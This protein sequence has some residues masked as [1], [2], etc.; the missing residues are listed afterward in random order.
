[1]ARGH[2]LGRSTVLTAASCAMT[3]TICFGIERLAF[4]A[5][6]ASPIEA[7]RD[8]PRLYVL[9]ATHTIGGTLGGALLGAV[10]N[11]RPINGMFALM[12]LMFLIGYGESKFQ[13]LVDEKQRIARLRQQY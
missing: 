8:I 4:V 9:L 1:M 2:Y 13:D 12:P 10:Y 5:I 6:Q 11:R 7:T 3:G